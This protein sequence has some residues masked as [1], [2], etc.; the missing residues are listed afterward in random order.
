MWRRDLTG[1]IMQG[2]WGSQ[3]VSC[4][5]IPH[6]PVSSFQ[7]PDQSLAPGHLKEPS[8]GG[9][10]I[11]DLI[12][13]PDG[14]GRDSSMFF[15][16]AHAKLFLFI[17]TAQSVV[18]ESPG[19]LSK[20]K[21]VQCAAAGPRQVVEIAGSASEEVHLPEGHTREGR[22][23]EAFASDHKAGPQPPDLMDQTVHALT[24]RHA[25]DE[26]VVEVA[27]IQGDVQEDRVEPQILLSLLDLLGQ[28]RSP[29]A[30]SRMDLDHDLVV[31]VL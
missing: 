31:T 28:D 9:I 17:A 20:E 21:I 19:N 7:T 5:S 16:D 27:G 12:G 24:G 18:T 3:R 25:F 1:D 23:I 2:L 22:F 11:G 10:R 15:M 14:N 6:C 30:Q 26:A 8:D 4:L 13:R 29:E